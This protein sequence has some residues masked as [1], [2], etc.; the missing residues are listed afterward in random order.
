MSS[1]FANTY[2][3]DFVTPPGEILEEKLQELGMTQ[4][5][6]A[7]RI[8]RTK[9]TVNEIVKGK[10]PLLPETTVQLERVLGIPARFWAN[11]E[12]NFRR[13]LARNDEAADLAGKQ[14]WLDRLPVAQLVKLGILSKRADPVDRLREILN[15]FGVASFEAMA[16]I[17]DDKCVAFRQSLAHEV[18]KYALLAWMRLGELQA[19]RIHCE[20]YDAQKFRSALRE[21][22][23]LS[24]A[25]PEN[26]LRRMRLLCAPAGV[27]LVFVQEMAGSRAWG[28]TQWISPEK[29]ILQLS[30]RGKS[31]DQFW[32]TFFHEAAHILLHP[33]KGVYVEIDS[34]KDEHEAE[35]DRF[36]RDM[37]IPPAEWKKVCQSRPRS[38]A[39]VR[40][41]ARRLGISPGILAGRLQHEHLL[42]WT[43]LSGLKVRLQFKALESAD[44]D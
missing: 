25:S 35:A 3:P 44:G 11:A 31:D 10:A 28:V 41:W 19:Q 22:R 17:G 24:T 16:R 4:A 7:E 15:F 39:Q 36:A 2:E 18:D 23:E 34:Q 1:Y 32:F 26:V 9:K 43:H 33:K 5:E 29:A 12:A 8:G 42:P 21:I 6:L 27:A 14:E 37:L 13:H 20:P 30:L 38:A 40:D